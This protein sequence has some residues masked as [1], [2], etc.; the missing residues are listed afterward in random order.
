MSK[1]DKPAILLKLEPELHAELTAAAKARSVSVTEWLKQAI[2]AKLDKPEPP[3]VDLFSVVPEAGYRIQTT[4]APALAAESE[5]VESVA[6]QSIQSSDKTATEYWLNQIRQWAGMPGA[7][8]MAQM[9]ALTGGNRPPA[10]LFASAE[11]L[12]K[13]L[14]ENTFGGDA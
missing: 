14:S 6:E 8:A 10:Q 1:N 5:P 12:A 2:K 4:I 9:L 7:E 11:K 3:A 13:W